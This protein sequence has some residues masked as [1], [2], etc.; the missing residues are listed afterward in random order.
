MK[1]VLSILVIALIIASCSKT[2]LLNEE[3]S[4]ISSNQSS[5]NVETRTSDETIKSFSGG[6]RFMISC[7]G[8]PGCPN[9]IPFCD[10]QGVTCPSRDVIIK[11]IKV[12]GLDEAIETNTQSNF[13]LTTLY[14][15]VFEELDYD[16]YI[17]NN[18]EKGTY[19]FLKTTNTS[20]GLT[21]Y[22]LVRANCEINFENINSCLVWAL[23]V[24]V[25]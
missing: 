6:R 24:E 22:V 17:Q 25:I 5:D 8:V 15:D 12:S 9:P 20:S 14:T 10:G 4:E 13:F 23:S 19:K 18:L 11:G 3:F 2:E 7:D 21:Y 1:K 16:Q